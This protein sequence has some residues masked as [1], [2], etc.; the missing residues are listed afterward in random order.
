MEKEKVKE[1]FY[2]VEVFCGVMG[3]VVD[4]WVCFIDII[5]IVFMNNIIR[6]KKGWELGDLGIMWGDVLVIDFIEDF[7][8]KV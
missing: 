4:V 1:F 6:E 7:F 2:Y 8:I 5:L 3:I